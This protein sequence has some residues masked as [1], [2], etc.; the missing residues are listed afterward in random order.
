[1]MMSVS[2]FPSSSRRDSGTGAG[3][4][5]GTGVALGAATETSVTTI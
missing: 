2:R 1:M 3:L 4:A 5:V